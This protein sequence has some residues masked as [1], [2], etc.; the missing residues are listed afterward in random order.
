M[1]NII[2]TIV[3]SA[4]RKVVFS[5][6]SPKKIPHWFGKGKIKITG[7]YEEFDFGYWYELKG[8][9]Y[10]NKDLWP[11]EIVGLKKGRMISFRANR[12]DIQSQIT[13]E[14][15]KVKGEKTRVYMTYSYQYLKTLK[16]IMNIIWIKRKIKK[17]NQEFLEKLKNLIVKEVEE[18]IEVE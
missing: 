16:R 7:E 10:K 17:I 13:W 14:F 2:N 8:W 11:L 1:T 5:Y 3:I 15:K 12:H 4:P 18:S 9:I 6:F